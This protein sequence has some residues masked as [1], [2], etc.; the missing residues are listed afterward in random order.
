MEDDF[1]SAYFE[2]DVKYIVTKK[3]TKGFTIVLNQ[4]APRELSFSWVAIAVNGAKTSYS[5]AKTMPVSVEVIAPPIP[6]ETV[7][8]SE[9]IIVPTGTPVKE[10]PQEEAVTPLVTLDSGN[11]TQIESPVTATAP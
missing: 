9:P 8:N 3:N 10:V 4:K 1:T 7:P 6:I 11:N 5:E 2:S